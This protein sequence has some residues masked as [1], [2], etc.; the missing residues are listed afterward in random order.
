MYEQMYGKIRTT[1]YVRR[2]NLPNVIGRINYI[3]N[4]EKQEFLEDYYDMANKDFWKEL[5][6]QSKDTKDYNKNKVDE[7]GKPYKPIQAVEY[8]VRLS[9]EMYDKSTGQLKCSA[10]D[11]AMHFYNHFGYICCV[12]VHHSKLKDENDNYVLNEQGNYRRNYNNLHC[13]LIICDRVKPDNRIKKY[14]TRDIY[15]DSN[16]KRVY[17]KSLA[18]PSKTIKK[19]ECYK[20]LKFGSKINEIRDN[21]AFNEKMHEWS[22]ILNND[23]SQNHFFFRPNNVGYNKTFEAQRKVGRNRPS[24]SVK[25]IKRLNMDVKRLNAVKEIALNNVFNKEPIPYYGFRYANEQLF[26][27]IGH[28]Y[29]KASEKFKTSL[30]RMAAY[31][32]RES[33]ISFQDSKKYDLYKSSTKGFYAWLGQNRT[34]IDEEIYQ[35]LHSQ[36]NEN[37]YEY[38]RTR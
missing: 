22:N 27:A 6:K 9:P 18:D 5:A 25:Y 3:S 33:R 35:Y 34:R 2:T 8:I 14:A 21:K 17:K 1:S 28:N 11:I 29:P 10:E 30:F 13:H 16:G 15:F 19:G 7:K 37:E 23:N 32:N 20:D 4:P 12:G 36:D 24:E 31:I 26:S 38:G